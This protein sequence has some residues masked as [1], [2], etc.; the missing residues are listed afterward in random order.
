M[1]SYDNWHVFGVQH[2]AHGSSAGSSIHDL[3]RPDSIKNSPGLSSIRPALR[4]YDKSNDTINDFPTSKTGSER[5]YVHVAARISTHVLRL[6]REHHLNLSYVQTSDPDCNHTVRLIDLLRLPSHHG[7]ELIVSIFESPA[8]SYLRDLLEFEQLWVPRIGQSGLPH[9]LFEKLAEDE[10]VDQ[11]FQDQTSLPIFLDFAVGACECLELLHHGLRAVHGEIRGDAF[12]FNK[13]TSTVKIINFGSGPRSFQNGLTS[14]GWSALSREAGII[15]KLQFIAPEQTGRM[16]AEPDSRTDIYSLGILFWTMLTRRWAFDGD[17]PLDVIQSVLSR[18]IPAVSTY[19]IDIPDVISEVI[20]KMTLKQIDERYHSISGLK[21]DLFQIQEMFGNGGSE[22]LAN[23]KIGSKDVSSFFVLPTNVFGRAFEYEQILKV[24][25]KVSRRLHRKS[26]VGNSSAGT[27]AMH[28]TSAST[29]SDNQLNMLNGSSKLTST[30]SDGRLDVLENDVRFSETSSQAA[31]ERNLAIPHVSSFGPEML[32]LQCDFPSNPDTIISPSKLLSS[33]SGGRDTVEFGTNL[34]YQSSGP[35]KNQYNGQQTASGSFAKS[36]GN[37]NF[38]RSRCEV[39]TIAGAAGLG[40]SSLIQSVQANIRRCGYFASAKFD[41]ARKAPFEHLLAAMSALFRQIFSE[42]ENDYH[43]FI[44]GN[45]GS[46][47]P[48]LSSVLNLPDNL[49][50]LDAQTTFDVES[51]TSQL[52]QKKF[53]RAELNESSS[54]SGGRNKS[55]RNHLTTNLVRGSANNP[56]SL[57]IMGIFIEV[58]RVLSAKRLICLCL[59]DLHFADEES[60]DVISNIM[61]RK[62]G[63]VLVVSYPYLD[64]SCFTHT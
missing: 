21:H 8:P 7:D 60:L 31:K 16:P 9:T 34:E 19:R 54:L 39:I 47:W 45:V 41:S 11:D 27:Q 35:Q 3:G 15:R 42:S 51:D 23:F 49:I 61:S 2:R 64:A 29:V 48:T 33:V 20:R 37:A 46:F 38:K 55:S 24:I 57:K 6:E 1:Q 17:T 44:R 58:L 22:N 14:V 13:N 43:A 32:S 53:L 25:D 59:D 30:I 36:R 26:N 52:S 62:L 56:R 5:T 28:S 50:S 40:K 63:I 12:Y 18:R 4:D 10:Y